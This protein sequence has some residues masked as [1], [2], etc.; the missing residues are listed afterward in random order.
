MKSDEKIHRNDGFGLSFLDVLCCGLGAAILLLLIV[1]HEKPSIDD[2][3][4][5]M[6]LEPEVMRLQ[7]TNHE[8]E[9]LLKRLEARVRS[10]GQEQDRLTEIRTVSMKNR[11]EIDRKIIVKRADLAGENAKL[12]ELNSLALKINNESQVKNKNFKPPENLNFGAISGVQFSGQD[13]VVVLLDSSTSMLHWSLVEIIRTQAM[14]ENV[15]RNA[16]KWRQ[17]GEIFELAYSSIE[18]GKRF[19]LLTF[20]EQVQDIA[21]ADVADRQIQWDTKSGLHD[22]LVRRTVNEP[23]SGGTNLANAIDAVSRL[24]PKPSKI[25]LITDGLPSRIADRGK[26]KGCPKQREKVVRV[27]GKCRGSI[28]I[29]SVKSLGGKLSEVPIDVILLPLEGDSEAVRFYSLITGMSAGR[30]IT[31]SVDWLL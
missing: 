12:R 20:S 9:S 1:K 13:K 15:M 21:G 4:M 3:T 29:E 23:P 14:G 6:M 10:L 25:V 24:T 30:L 11:S 5:Q 17:A 7:A 28:A 18:K 19:K 31:P 2:S 22:S 26:L 27:S 8:A 16:R